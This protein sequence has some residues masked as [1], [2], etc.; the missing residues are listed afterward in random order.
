MNEEVLKAIVNGQAEDQTLWTD[1]GSL[2]HTRALQAALRVLHEE[3]EGKT[4][5]QCARDALKKIH[6]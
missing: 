1:V 2:H 4:S 5:E 6:N 3:I